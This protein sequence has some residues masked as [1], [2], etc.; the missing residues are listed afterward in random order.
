MNTKKP[1]L[2][3]VK[4]KDYSSQVCDVFQDFE[5]LESKF[6]NIP[7]SQSNL[8]SIK[9]KKHKSLGLLTLIF[10]RL[11]LT[12]G[13]EISLDEATESILSECEDANAQFKSKVISKTSH[14]YSNRVEDYTILPML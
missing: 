9:T 5:N 7:Q 12:K 11:F 1:K 3:S 8:I 13:R 2:H 14:K 6:L 10:I 4:A